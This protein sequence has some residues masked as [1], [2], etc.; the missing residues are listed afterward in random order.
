MLSPVS[1]LFFFFLAR[2]QPV[3]RLGQNLSD[4]LWS[5]NSVDLYQ[6]S[7]RSRE[8]FSLLSPTSSGFPCML[9]SSGYFDSICLEWNLKSILDLDLRACA[10]FTVVPGSRNWLWFLSP[11]ERR[12][13]CG[14]SLRTLSSLAKG[15]LDA[16]IVTWLGFQSQ[17]GILKADRMTFVM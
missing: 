9:V 1:P 7:A 13:K 14:S 11:V 2:G 16:H 4:S 12:V 6:L 17:C 8:E 5:L 3:S 15:R 10:K